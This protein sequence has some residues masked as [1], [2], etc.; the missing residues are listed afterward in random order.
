MKMK[1]VFC[2][3]FAAVLA[4]TTG[5]GPSRDVDTLLREA[6]AENA[7]GRPEEALA[8]AKKA[9]SQDSK[10]ADALI[11][12]AV[13]FE[14]TGKPDAAVDSAKKA[15]ELEPDSFAAQYTLGRLYSLRRE[16]GPDALAAL[17]KAI[18]IRPGD[19]DT[20]ILLANVAMSLHP[21]QAKSYLFAL[22][23]D[24]RLRSSSEYQNQLGIILARSNSPKA[25]GEAFLAGCRVPGASPVIS[26]NLA[27]C[28]DL[29]L[30]NPRSAA[31][32]YRRYLDLAPGDEINAEPRR[33]AEARLRA[34]QRR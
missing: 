30:N 18:A 26:F 1:Y 11:F 32:L 22:A 31:A 7:A 20:L 10:R 6:A 3:T 28:M 19:R 8:L 14:K 9:V 12:Q 4:F 33:V 25:A 24:S 15:A 13:M 5:C 2:L 29:Y 23:R 34:L 16:S 21:D 17:G 27:R